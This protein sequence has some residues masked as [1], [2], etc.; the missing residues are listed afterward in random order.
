METLSGGKKD[1]AYKANCSFI[2][3]L[4]ITLSCGNLSINHIRKVKALAAGFR[5][6]GVPAAR[7]FI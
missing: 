7:V 3:K 6:Y 1:R 5:L 4:L 2:G